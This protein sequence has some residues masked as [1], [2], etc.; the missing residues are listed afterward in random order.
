MIKHMFAALFLAVLIAV[1]VRS[2][3]AAAEV[4]KTDGEAKYADHFV[5]RRFGD[6]EVI[7]LLDAAG[8]SEGSTKLLIGAGPEDL[9]R[10]AKPGALKNSINAFV[11][12]L[13]GKTILFDAGLPEKMS[14]GM[15]P[16]LEA[17]GLK[18][19]DIDA[20]VITHFHFDHVGGLL[21]D[22][23][24]VFPRAEL[25]VP[26]VEVDKWSDAGTEFLVAY[27][28]YTIVFESDKE[29]LPG[30]TSRAAYGHTPGH[31]VFLLESE[32]GKLLI[33]GDLIHIPGVQLA[34]PD[35]AVTYDVDPVKAVAAR[36][37]IFDWAA[38]E[39]LP[40]AAM[41]MPFPGWGVLSKDGKGY[42]FAEFKQD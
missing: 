8:M 10:A 29:F 14:A 3:E 20:I 23:K 40:V 13:N 41:H 6:I 27:Q 33:L 34:N 36:R 21:R 25:Y 4:E 38:D 7:A 26:R 39:K 5:S 42:G 28:P 15:L 16:A 19:D 24:K 12:K 17:A 2:G 11:V 32:G 18:V 1:P 9:E 37:K 35:V 30:V 22:G 31:T